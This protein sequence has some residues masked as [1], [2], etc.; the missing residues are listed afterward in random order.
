MGL[1]EEGGDEFAPANPQGLLVELTVPY[2]T[3]EISVRSSHIELGPR[4]VVRGLPVLDRPLAPILLQRAA[5]PTPSAD[6][7]VRGTRG[8][9]TIIHGADVRIESGE[10]HRR[11]LAPGP[12]LE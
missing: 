11:L 9:A 3:S 4:T 1:L 12:K 8:R 10:G 5:G 7:E 2:C 6:G